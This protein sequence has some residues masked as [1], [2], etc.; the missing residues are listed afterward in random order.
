[1]YPLG[2]DRNNRIF[3]FLNFS[4]IFFTASGSTVIVGF[5]STSFSVSSSIS[6]S[7]FS[8]SS[9]SIFNS[10][11]FSISFKISSISLSKSI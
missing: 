5:S 2:Q 10:G 11:S 6:L 7:I 1:V 9:S 3:Y 8:I 4:F